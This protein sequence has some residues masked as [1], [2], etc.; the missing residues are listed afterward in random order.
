MQTLHPSRESEGEAGGNAD[1]AAE[2]AFQVWFQVSLPVSL[3]GGT[4]GAAPERGVRCPAVALEE[5]TGARR[6]DPGSWEPAAQAGSVGV[7]G[8]FCLWTRR[9]W[10]RV[11]CVFSCPPSKKELKTCH[12]IPGYHTGQVRCKSCALHHILRRGRNS[13]LAWRAFRC[14]NTAAAN[15]LRRFGSR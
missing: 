13:T 2:A 7:P 10:V 14:G 11:D 6:P 12:L 3:R 15:A 8:R 5:Q 4:R 9:D 1:P